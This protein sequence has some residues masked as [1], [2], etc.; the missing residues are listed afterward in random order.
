MK[1]SCR[2]T[3]APP[4]LGVS[5]PYLLYGQS[6]LRYSDEA[7]V[8]FTASQCPIQAYAYGTGPIGICLRDRSLGICL[9]DRFHKHMPMGPVHEH[10]L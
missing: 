10:V 1:N 3:E 4:F 5:T 8:F 7:P 9:W 2:D 6:I